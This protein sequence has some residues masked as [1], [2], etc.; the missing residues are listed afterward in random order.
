MLGT[1]RKYS[2]ILSNIG[3]KTEKKMIEEA[4]YRVDAIYFPTQKYK[5]K[6]FFFLKIIGTGWN[7]KI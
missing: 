4:I 5:K 2:E 6:F 3:E 7:Y 1:T